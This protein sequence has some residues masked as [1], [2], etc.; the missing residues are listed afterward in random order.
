M[1]RSSVEISFG[2]CA[3]DAEQHAAVEDGAGAQQES[4]SSGFAE[5]GRGAMSLPYTVF[6]PKV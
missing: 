5:A 2:Y 1:V 4:E 6:S 3:F